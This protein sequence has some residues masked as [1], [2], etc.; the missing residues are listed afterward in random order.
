FW[1]DQY[2][3]HILSYGLPG[4]ADSW[5]LMAETFD[6]QCEVGY[7]RNQRLVGVAGVGMRSA[8]LGLRDQIGSDI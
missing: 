8:L 7:F 3:L 5:H 6:D 4:S 2:D 1:T